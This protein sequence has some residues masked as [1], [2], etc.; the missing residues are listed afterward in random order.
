MRTFLTTLC[1]LIFLAIAESTVDGA[2]PSPD[3]ALL[4]Q[5]ILATGDAQTDLIAK[6]SQPTDPVLVRTILTDWIKGGVY[7]HQQT[8]GSMVPFTMEASGPVRIDTG[9][10]LVA[11]ENTPVDTDSHL[12]RAV[13]STLDLLG[14]ADPDPALRKSAVMKLG[15][16]QKPQY[17][18][19]LQTCMDKEHNGTVRQALQEAIAIIHLNDSDPGVQK[20]AIQKL[21]DLDS[22][23]SMDLL[24][25]NWLPEEPF[26]R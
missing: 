5:A 13:R 4:S 2:T 7:L 15:M 19:A 26:H 9:E 12:R 11:T 24:K 20:A 16:L 23:S 22:I 3:R 14:L 1:F 17:L 6:L 25:Y 18:P 8:D 21:A 10:P